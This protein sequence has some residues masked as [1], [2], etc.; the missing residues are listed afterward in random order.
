MINLKGGRFTDLLPNNLASQIEVQALAYAIGRQIDTICAYADNARVYAALSNVPEIVLDILAA[1]L[2]TPAYRED[3][4]INVKRALIEGTIIFYAKMGTP[5]A[6]NRIIRA[7]FGTGY[8][9]EWFDY[10]GE[11]YHFKAY[12]TNPTVTQAGVAEFIKVLNT[13]KR[14]SAWLDEIILALSTDAMNTYIGF[15]VHTGDFI[16][17]NKTVL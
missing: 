11:P 6:V 9:K 5:S 16:K 3:Y 10:G 13:V 17:L 15:W 14:L 12:T 1:E 4:S 7:I 2:R 8:I